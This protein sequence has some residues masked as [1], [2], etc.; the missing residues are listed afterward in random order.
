MAKPLQDRTAL[1]TG[2]SRGIGAATAQRLAADGARVAIHFNQSRDRADALARTITDGGG[3]AAVIGGDLATPTG[4]VDLVKAAFAALGDIDILIN[5]A[6]VFEG[7]ALESLTAEQIDHVLAVNLRAVLLT[8][9]EFAAATHTRHGRVVNISSIAARVPAGGGSLYAASKAA[10]ESL[11]RSH[12]TELGPRGITVNAV[13]PGTT[14][15]DMSAA[16]FPPGA[17][18]IIVKGT[19]LG[20][21]GQPDDIAKVV[22][23]LCTDDAAWITGQVLGADGGMLTGGLNL[24]RMGGGG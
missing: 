15:T 13:A 22:A 7:K 19:A 20:R 12:A 1:V 24:I 8:T 10:V 14:E 23:L 6:G 2:S 17:K 21:F 9:R 4:P 18:A 3:R 16:G 11:T 5:N